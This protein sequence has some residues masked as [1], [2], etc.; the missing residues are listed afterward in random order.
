MTIEKGDRCF[1]SP[2]LCNLDR[3][4]SLIVSEG[5]DSRH[6][7]RSGQRQVDTSNALGDVTSIRQQQLTIFVNASV[8]ALEHGIF[9]LGAVS[10]TEIVGCRDPTA[11]RLVPAEII[12]LLL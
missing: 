4:T 6:G 11:R 7:F 5:E 10:D 3:S 12:F 9:D 1:A 8:E 2:L